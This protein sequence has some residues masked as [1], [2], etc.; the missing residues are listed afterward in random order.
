[1]H[2]SELIAIVV[3]TTLV[4]LDLPIPAYEYYTILMVW[5]LMTTALMFGNRKVEAA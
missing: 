5:L 2:V 1:M 3:L 4:V